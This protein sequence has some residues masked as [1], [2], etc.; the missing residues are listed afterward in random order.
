MNFDGE[1]PR[2]GKKT[3]VENEESRRFALLS[4]FAGSVLQKLGVDFVAGE[5]DVADH[6][7]ADKA[8]LHRQL[9]EDN[10]I[11]N[12]SISGVRG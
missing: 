10:H 6:G 2:N 4:F 7:A 9:R 8:V 1:K 3:P 5:L 11:A 12:Q